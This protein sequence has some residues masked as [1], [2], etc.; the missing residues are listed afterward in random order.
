[1]KRIAQIGYSIFW[2]LDIFSGT[3][4]LP[5]CLGHNTSPDP[6]ALSAKISVPSGPSVVNSGFY[7]A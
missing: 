3:R 5:C 6:P 4:L 7:E 1:M 2:F